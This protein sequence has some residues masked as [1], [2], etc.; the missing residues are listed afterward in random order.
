L[1][2]VYQILFHGILLI[3]IPTSF[4]HLQTSTKKSTITF[5]LLSIGKQIAGEYVGLTGARLDGSEMLA[6][7]LATHFVPSSVCYLLL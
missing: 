4:E 7:G 2:N 3:V 5:F 1:D 6:C